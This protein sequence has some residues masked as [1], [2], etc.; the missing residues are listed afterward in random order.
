MAKLR[1]VNTKFWDDSFIS[2]LTPTEKLLFLYLI[3]NP[4]TNLIG[5]YEISL[6]K[7]C[8]DTGLNNEIVSKG[9]ERFEK[10]KKVFYSENYIILPNWLKNQNLNSN[11]KV[12]VVKEF[13]QL[14]NVLVNSILNNDLEQLPNDYESIRN[15]LETI[16]DL[17]RIKVEVES[18]DELKWKSNFEV[19]KNDLRENYNLLISDSEFIEQQ[20]KYFPGVDIK[21]SLEKACVNFWATEAGW[22]HKIKERSKVINWKSTLTNAIGLNKVY[23]NEKKETLNG[24]GETYFQMLDRIAKGETK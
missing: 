18:K 15:A 23:K 13:E 12:A 2:E 24:K 16:R 9:L 3:T 10:V 14:P 8:F 7:I 19:Y 20:E 4:L 11:M 17:N 6:R 1:S 21:L 22:R 5:I